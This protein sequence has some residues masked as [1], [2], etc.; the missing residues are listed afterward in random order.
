METYKNI[1]LKIQKQKTKELVMTMLLIRVKPKF[2]CLKTIEN[3]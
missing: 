1:F 3:G 2:M